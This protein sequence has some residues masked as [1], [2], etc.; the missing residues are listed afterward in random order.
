MAE[1]PPDAPATERVAAPAILGQLDKL[2]RA[3][4]ICHP[5][6]LLSHSPRLSAPQLKDTEGRIIFPPDTRN[7]VGRGRKV[8]KPFTPHTPAELLEGW[9]TTY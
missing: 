1:D 9:E 8:N 7:I 4:V 5:L 3:L 2:A 6:R